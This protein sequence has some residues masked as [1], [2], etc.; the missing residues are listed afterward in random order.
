LKRF[1]NRSPPLSSDFDFDTGCFDTAVVDNMVPVADID[2]TAAA[3]DAA[4]AHNNL[5]DIEVADIEP[6]VAGAVDRDRC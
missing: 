6:S 2:R 3:A 5:A 4:A 1:V